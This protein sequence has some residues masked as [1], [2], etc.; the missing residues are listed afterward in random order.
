[1]GKQ[2]L[3]Q[4]TPLKEPTENSEKAKRVIQRAMRNVKE[5]IHSFVYSVSIFQLIPVEEETKLATDGL[6]MF[7]HP[8]S[9]LS[10]YSRNRTM[11]LEN[12]IIHI[13]FHGMMGHFEEDG[14]Y[15][16]QRL[17]WAIND[18]Q[19]DQM[20]RL[21]QNRAKLPEFRYD[22]EEY[23]ERYIDNWF[24]KETYFQAL[25]NK[26]L[27]KCIYEE[28]NEYHVDNHHIWSMLK[29]Q[30][31]MDEL[32]QQIRDYLEAAGEQQAG[33]ESVKERWDRARELLSG[34]ANVDYEQLLQSVM[35]AKSRSNQH[36]TGAGN[37]IQTVHASGKGANSYEEILR[38]FFTMA[39]SQTEQPDTID[40]MM[41]QYG[42]DLYEDV[43][44]VEPLETSE[45]YRF[46]SM[47]LAIDT[48]GSCSGNIVKQFLR[49][50][51]SIFEEVG[52]LAEFDA[53]HFVQ[54]DWAIHEHRVIDSIQELSDVSEEMQLKGFGGTS[55]EPVFE[56]TNRLVE[57]E[58][59][60]IDCLLYLTDTYGEF[61]DQKPEYPVILIVPK[62][63]VDA[64][65]KPYNR[66]IPNWVRTVVLE[67][68]INGFS[69][70]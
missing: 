18:R 53:I 25:Q 45:K 15:E 7:Y 35:G 9:V 57:E 32:A 4:L 10:E 58:Q 47:V 40:P 44:L 38:E 56:L 46:H 22:D 37:G 28:R 26:S 61:P 36:G 41:Y 24:G 70:F 20:K 23:A 52:Q 30:K 48:S 6:H 16:K 19:V 27:A 50:T 21:V 2:V 49:E 13:I 34:S 14:Q 64:N 51:I 42:L 3:K 55:F 11:N 60:T 66:E 54:C 63:D 17:A 65:G 29:R 62:E 1:M 69:P 5:Q 31:K 68:D 67:T 59:E 43:P 39:D 12:E 8:A 33:D